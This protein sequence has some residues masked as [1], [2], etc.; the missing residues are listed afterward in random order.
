MADIKWIKLDVGIFEDEKIKLI[1]TMPKGETL[2]LIWLKLLCL[3]GRVNNSGVLMVNK[4]IPYTVKMLS[5]VFNETSGM[6]K[7]AI[8]TFQKL[9]MVDEYK[10]TLLLPNWEKHQAEDRLEKIKETSRASSAKYRHK[11]KRLAESRDMTVTSPSHDSDRQIITQNQNQNQNKNQ[12]QNENTDTGVQGEETSTG[13]AKP[14][15]ARTG[16]SIPTADDVRAYCVQR[17]NSVDAERFV[18]YYAMKGWMIRGDK[19]KDWKAA[20]RTW[21]KN[22]YANGQRAEPKREYIDTDGRW[23]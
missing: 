5:A 3:A 15:R 4:S 10:G 22:G 11:Q 6:I 2:L 14:S 20:V 13:K 21:E 9:G 18:D 19:L 1:L 7:L 16:F 17:G 8:N 12:N 23:D